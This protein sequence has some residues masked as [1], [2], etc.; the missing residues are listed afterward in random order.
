MSTLPGC[1][2]GER[3]L[4]WPWSRASQSKVAWESMAALVGSSETLVEVEI[5]V[6]TLLRC[7]LEPDYSNNNNQRSRSRNHHTH[8]EPAAHM[9]AADCR[10]HI[11]SHSRHQHEGARIA[12][13]R[14]DAVRGWSGALWAFRPIPVDAVSVPSSAECNQNHLHSQVCAVACGSLAMRSRQDIAAERHRPS[15]A[16]AGTPG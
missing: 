13:A 8:I 12:I 7:R 9:V 15:I 6:W 4:Q 14:D 2:L 1:R 16:E 3:L 5:V 11:R 10:R